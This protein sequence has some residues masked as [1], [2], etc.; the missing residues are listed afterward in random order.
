MAD[1]DVKESLVATTRDPLMHY[2]NKTIIIAV[3]VLAVLMVF[4]IIWSV[5]DVVLT[6]VKQ[7]LAPPFLLFN[8]EDLVHLF[9][10]F[11]AVLIGIEIF[12]NIVFYLKQD[13]IH[14]PL[15]LATALTAISRKV[16][17]LDYNKLTA[18]YIYATAL[19]VFAVG[20]VF[21]L[22]TRKENPT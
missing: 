15:V 12:L 4:L 8:F 2:L 5:I 13:A 21:W 22:V 16:I 3:K 19:V 20:I 1:N 17:I 9:G 10:N 18:D 14:V 11:L 7:F 6:I